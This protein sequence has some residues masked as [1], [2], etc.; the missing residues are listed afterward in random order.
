MLV[1][2][3]I[4]FFYD[5]CQTNHLNIYQTSRHQYGVEVRLLI[6]DLKL[7]FRPVK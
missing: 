5:F 7:V 3:F 1:V 6:T 4:L 2:H